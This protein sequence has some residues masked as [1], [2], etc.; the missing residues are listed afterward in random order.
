MKWLQQ[1]PHIILKFKEKK[2]EKINNFERTALALIFGRG[3]EILLFEIQWLHTDFV[4]Y[5]FIMFILNG[6]IKIG[7]YQAHGAPHSIPKCLCAYSNYD[8]NHTNLLSEYR[9]ETADIGQSRATSLL[10]N[11]Q[12]IS[13]V[14]LSHTYI[15][16]IISLSIC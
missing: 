5:L 10:I 12:Y 4:I 8:N 14:S 3:N 2:E 15:F 13:I 16:S 6:A 11:T 1:I 7:A 9:P